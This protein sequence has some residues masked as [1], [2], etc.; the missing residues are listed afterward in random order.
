MGSKPKDI[1][2][3]RFG[4]LVAIK[5]TG[6]KQN[7]SYSWLCKCDCGN[8][9]DVSYGRLN[10][11]ITQSCGCL[12]SKDIT[13]Q[14]F[15]KLLVLQDSGKRAK[16]RSKLWM[17]ECDCGNVKQIKTGNLVSGNTLSCGCHKLEAVK[18]N[19]KIAHAKH[20]KEQLKEGTKLSMLT[21]K[22]PKSNTSGVKG[23][24]WNK[25]GNAWVARITF[26][27]DVMYL[28]SFT[29]LKDATN[30]RR[31]AEEKYFKPILEK[32]GKEV[33]SG[34]KRSE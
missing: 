17:C 24:C 4:K 5:S 7:G 29:N 31:E 12:M 19:I 8:E 16:D 13:G 18:E 27:G 30:A 2:G 9:K 32:Y 23:V 10:N 33:S 34:Y 26:K 25:K 15:G 14:R 20:A 11:K 6:E 1:T 21:E 3:K 22:I 28:G